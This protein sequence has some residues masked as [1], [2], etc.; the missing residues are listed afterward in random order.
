ML[1]SGDNLYFKDT[2]E[3]RTHPSQ[4]IFIYEKMVGFCGRFGSKQY[5]PTKWGIMAYT[6][7]YAA[8]GAHLLNN[9]VYT[10]KLHVCVHPLN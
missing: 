6:L 1:E 5:M 3:L 8:N 7:A 4:H 10:G 2:P 9:L